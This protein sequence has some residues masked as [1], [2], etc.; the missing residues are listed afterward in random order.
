VNEQ[1]ELGELEFLDANERDT[2]APV[3]RRLL[4]NTRLLLRAGRFSLDPKKL[5]SGVQRLRVLVELSEREGANPEGDP[6]ELFGVA[7][8]APRK[9]KPGKSG[10]VLNSGRQVTAWV[11][12]E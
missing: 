7:W 4:D 5:E 12:I 2:L 1:G 8:E 6:G 11:W 10:F 3:V 9:D